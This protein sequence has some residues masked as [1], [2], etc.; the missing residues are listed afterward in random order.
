MRPKR[1]IDAGAVFSTAAVCFLIASALSS[2]CVAGEPTVASPPLTTG[3]IVGRLV[4]ANARRSQALRG[5][6]GR[7]DYKVSYHSFLS[8]RDAEMQVQ[9]S[10][11]APDKKNFSVVS[12]TGSKLLIN[13]VLLKLLDS[14]K[15]ALQQRNRMESELSPRNYEFTLADTEHSAGGDQYVLSV[16]P[17][18][19]SKFLY[20]GKIWVD[21]QDFAVVRM[22]GEPAKN[23]SFWISRTRIEYEFT[24]IGEFWFPAHTKSETQVRM[25]GK[26]LL[27]IDYTDYEIS[28]AG[29][30]RT[31]RGPD[32]NPVL[33][34][35]SS[36]I[37]EQH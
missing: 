32:K 24:K 20:N 30:T 19:A 27:T 29:K 37:P 1:Q 25:G 3:T 12:Q 36:V 11:S 4:A 34:D 16:K 15:E 31:A 10:Y 22:E 2:E 23:P 5:Y 17:R 8:S 9:V 33:L 28:T 35:P 13:H 26:A 7:R 6:Q 18:V 21:A 14:E